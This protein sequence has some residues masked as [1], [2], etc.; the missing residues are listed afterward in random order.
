VNRWALAWAVPVLVASCSS[1]SKVLERSAPE[2]PAWVDQAPAARGQLYFTGTCTDLPNYQ[3]GLECARAEA[4]LDVTAWVGG[5]FSSYVYGS[6]TE[7]GRRAGSSVYFDSD[8]FLV[9]VRRED[10]YYEIRQETWGRSY[11]VSVLLSYPRQAA[12]AERSEIVKKT[13]WCDGFVTGAEHRINVAASEGRWGDAMNGV[14]LA[15]TEVAVPR[16]FDRS[17]HLDRLAVI[18]RDL[19]TP[20]RIS[21]EIIDAQVLVRTSYRGAAAGGVPLECLLG[22]QKVAAVSGTDGTAVCEMDGSPVGKGEQIKVRPDIDSYLASVPDEAGGLAAVLGELLDRSDAIDVSVRLDVGVALTGDRECEPALRALRSSLSA[23]GVRFVEYGAGQASLSLTCSVEDGSMSG[24]LF[25][26]VARG[27]VVLDLAASHARE[28]VAPV[29]GLGA[30][31]V[32]A[33]NE[34]LERLGSELGS[35]A[36]RLLSGMVGDEEG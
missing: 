6:T 13:G 3:E 4:L 34:A 7:Q 30:S 32:A 33:R 18:A 21:A 16:N 14:L 28:S 11:F 8:V 12:E 24:S 35:V 29:N 20:F 25:S 5:R 1:S 27:H 17:Q 10:T 19:V 23:A 26:A 15:A 22:R 9:D 31:A 2:R 36:L